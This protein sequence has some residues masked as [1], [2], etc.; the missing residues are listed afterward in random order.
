[1]RSPDDGETAE[2]V[3]LHELPDEHASSS[4]AKPSAQPDGAGSLP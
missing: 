4:A 2:D 3:Y 1:M